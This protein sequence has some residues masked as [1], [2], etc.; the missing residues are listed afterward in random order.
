MQQP[1]AHLYFLTVLEHLMN[2]PY[3]LSGFVRMATSIKKSINTLGICD[4]SKAVL[5]IELQA[6][7]Q[8][9]AQQLAL[10]LYPS[11]RSDVIQYIIIEDLNK[12]MDDEITGGGPKG[13]HGMVVAL[14][15]FKLLQRSS[16]KFTDLFKKKCDSVFKGINCLEPFYCQLQV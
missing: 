13:G 4:A 10:H 2:K 9:I 12:L 6:V 15:L 7:T 16:R 1:L 3:R 14:H 11:E 8:V 5:Y